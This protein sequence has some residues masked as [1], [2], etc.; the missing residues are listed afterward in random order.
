MKWI[1][2]VLYIL[3]LIVEGIG[4]EKAISK[5]SSKFGVSKS[6]IKSIYK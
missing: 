4:E 2:I 6:F 5:A 3:K 1:G